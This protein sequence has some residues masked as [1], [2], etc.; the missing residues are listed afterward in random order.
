MIADFTLLEA[1]TANEN[2][3]YSYFG[4]ATWC[5]FDLFGQKREVARDRFLSVAYTLRPPV[6]RG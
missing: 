6:S 2:N 3:M 5:I 4:V 1:V